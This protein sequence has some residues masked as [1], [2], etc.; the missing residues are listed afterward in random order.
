MPYKKKSPFASFSDPKR[1]VRSYNPTDFQMPDI[2]S[3]F[4]KKADGEVVTQ[5]SKDKDKGTAADNSITPSLAK[6]DKQAEQKEADVTRRSLRQ[7][8]RAGEK[9]FNKELRRNRRLSKASTKDITAKER[10]F[11][12]DATDKIQGEKD[13]RKEAKK[14]GF[15][16]ADYKDK[17]LKDKM[18][19]KVK[20]LDSKDYP[21]NFSFAQEISEQENK[22]ME[23]IRVSNGSAGWTDYQAP[24]ND[25]PEDEYLTPTQE[26]KLQM[27]KNPLGRG[28]QMNKD[29]KQV[30]SKG[31][32][33][34]MIQPNQNTAEQQMPQQMPNR[35][36]RSV[37]SNQLVND[38]NVNQPMNKVPASSF[39]RNAQ[40]GDIASSPGVPNP[41][42]MPNTIPQT[43]VFPQQPNQQQGAFAAY[44]SPDR[45]QNTE[46]GSVINAG[47]NMQEGIED[48]GDS[49]SKKEDETNNGLGM[50]DG[51]SKA[52][53]G[54]QD[55]LP[56]HL[57]A[58]IEAAPGMY[59]GPSMKSAFKAFE[60]D[61]LKT[62][63]TKGNLKA[64]ERDDAAHMSY[65]K[66]DVKYDNTHGG[67]NKQMLND[68]KHIS[69]LAGDLKYDAK[70]KRS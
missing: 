61:H 52:L 29:M 19:D 46:A 35:A 9:E 14:E 27:I 25:P 49:F 54:N 23:R 45:V 56:E 6:L 20:K 5:A 22:P 15:N 3:I 7:D 59:D 44:S 48:L 16:P 66:R 17:L 11:Y 51:P 1:A 58:K 8:R 28:L 30:N 69:K 50:Y 55:R 10:E 40:F 2:N 39:Q 41:A 34:P 21:G 60:N 68:E 62:K 63:V 12:E 36:G 24:F 31:S 26:K 53:V 33:F 43:S 38:P 42:P 70:K 18:R 4:E 64:T 65:L 67:S 13:F 32:G 37:E 47:R 57:K